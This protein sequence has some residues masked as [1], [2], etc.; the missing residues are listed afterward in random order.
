M[1]GCLLPHRFSISPGNT[2]DRVKASALIE[3]ARALFSELIADCGYDSNA[4]RAA[5]ALQGP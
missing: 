4:V 1:T 3:A 5:F 2:R